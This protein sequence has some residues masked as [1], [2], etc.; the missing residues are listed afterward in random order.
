[1]S[2]TL[3]AMTWAI[4][5]TPLIGFWPKGSRRRPRRLRHI[6][7][8]IH[9]E[10]ALIRG[11]RSGAVYGPAGVTIFRSHRRGPQLFQGRRAAAG[12]AARPEP[13]GAQTR[14]RARC[15]AH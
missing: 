4:F 13:A 10:A 12:G 1:M 11:S 14:G 2:L 7:D 9:A 15:R 6:I 8:R 3:T 5:V